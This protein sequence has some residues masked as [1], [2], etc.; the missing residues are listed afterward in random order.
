[1]DAQRISLCGEESFGTGSDHIREKDGVWALL[2]EWARERAS[3]WVSEWVSEWASECVLIIFFVILVFFEVYLTHLKL[4]VRLMIWSYFMQFLKDHIWAIVMT[5]IAFCNAYW[6]S[7]KMLQNHN[8]HRWSDLF[9][10]A[11]SCSKCLTVH[12][13]N[14]RNYNS[15]LG[16]LKGTDCVWDKANGLMSP[17]SEITYRTS[18]LGQWRTWWYSWWIQQHLI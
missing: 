11:C 12:S 13:H 5:K 18:M 2:G 6:N 4:N 15:G 16:F 1:M 17:P 3:E 8:K 14:A 7:P 10:F 9:L